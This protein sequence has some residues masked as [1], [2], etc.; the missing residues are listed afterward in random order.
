MSEEELDAYRSLKGGG[1]LDGGE[2][3]VTFER[4]QLSCL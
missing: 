1:G 4:K 2:R 3:L